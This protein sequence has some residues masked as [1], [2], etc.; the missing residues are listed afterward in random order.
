MSGVDWWI[1]GLVDWQPLIPA[2]SPYEGEKDIRSLILEHGSNLDFRCV[3]KQAVS[4]CRS[5][6]RSAGPPAGKRVVSSSVPHTNC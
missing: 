5:S 3:G 6:P 1:G 4:G 2:F